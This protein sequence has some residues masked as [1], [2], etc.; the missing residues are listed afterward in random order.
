[1]GVSDRKSYHDGPLSLS[2]KDE[3]S[4]SPPPPRSQEHTK[5]D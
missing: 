4:I 2:S 3:A 5:T 1:M